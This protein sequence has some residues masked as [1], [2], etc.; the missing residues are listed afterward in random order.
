[1]TV[2]V[3]R[4]RSTDALSSLLSTQ[5]HEHGDGVIISYPESGFITVC[6]MIVFPREARELA[7]LMRRGANLRNDFPRQY[8]LRP[9]P[10]QPGSQVGSF[11]IETGDDLFA[12]YVDDVPLTST[13]VSYYARLLEEAATA[14]TC[15]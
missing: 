15:K 3:P 2:A 11:Y 13:D 7:Q 10:R 1:M 12:L 6:H 14:A 8:V 9:N 4:T 5:G